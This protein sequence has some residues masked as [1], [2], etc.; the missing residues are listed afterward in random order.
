MNLALF[1]GPCGTGEA[2]I[3]PLQTIADGVS[4][5]LP[6]HVDLVGVS[7]AL[8]GETLAVVFQLRDVPETLVFDR[9][10]VGERAYEYG[11]EVSIDVDPGQESGQFGLDYR[12]SAYHT[13]LPENKESSTTAAIGSKV[14]AYTSKRIQDSFRKLGEAVIVVSPYADTITLVGDI[15]GITPDSRLIFDV[16]DSVNGSEYVGCQELPSSE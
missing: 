5:E 14:E 1:P 7:T 8:S 16:Y 4:E 12:M 13:V 9:E 2:M 6:A 10:G 15:P 11:W 3:K